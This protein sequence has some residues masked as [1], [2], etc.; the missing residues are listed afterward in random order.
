[1]RQDLSKLTNETWSD[2]DD[3]KNHRMI[4][5]DC[6]ANKATNEVQSETKHFCYDQFILDFSKLENNSKHFCNI[7][8]KIILKNESSTSVESNFEKEIILE[9]KMSRLESNIEINLEC[10]KCQ[11]YKQ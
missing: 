5:E 7:D 10:E 1:M 2:M 3:E 4:C 8:P 11:D 9:D 6:E